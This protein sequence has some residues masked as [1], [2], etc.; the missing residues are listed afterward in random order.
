[1]PLESLFEPP[2]GH[3]SGRRHHCH[4]PANIDTADSLRSLL[5]PGRGVRPAAKTADRRRAADWTSVIGT[6]CARATAFLAAVLYT[7]RRP[8]A[9]A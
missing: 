1:M 3:H 6:R 9:R 5:R 8:I 7:R 4:R 2:R